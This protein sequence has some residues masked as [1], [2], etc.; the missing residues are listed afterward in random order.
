LV[1]GNPG[2]GAMG[3]DIFSVLEEKRKSDPSAGTHEDGKGTAKKA[4][5][6]KAKNPILATTEKGLQK[7]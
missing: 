6:P 7:L 3:G 4:K 5:K 2:M 1:P